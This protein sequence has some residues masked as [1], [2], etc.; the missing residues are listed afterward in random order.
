MV[1]SQPSKLK[2]DS[3]SESQRVFVQC[4]RLLGGC[5]LKVGQ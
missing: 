2:S 4:D 3:A 5:G 1:E